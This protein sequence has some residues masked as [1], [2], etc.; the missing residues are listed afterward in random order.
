[1]AWRT[2]TAATPL[3]VHEGRLLM[4]RERL[5][6]GLWWSVPGGY[7]DGGESLEEAAAREADE[8]TGVVVSVGP[9]VCTLVWHYLAK[10]RRNVIAYFEATAVGDPAPRPQT[11]EAIETAELVVPTDLPAD[12][13]HPQTRAVLDRWWPRRG[14]CPPFHLNAD[15]VTPSGSETPEYVFRD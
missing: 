12:E 11:E 14:D 10:E 3:V 15:I 7:A 13:I 8:E 1:M 6:S 9:L 4:I 5:P 2:L